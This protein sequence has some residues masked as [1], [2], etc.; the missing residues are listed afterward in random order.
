MAAAEALEAELKAAPKPVWSEVAA[1]LAETRREL[2]LRGK[3]KG[4]SSLSS[5]GNVRGIQ[6]DAGDD[7]ARGSIIDKRRK[8][9]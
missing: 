8:S 7:D 2:S 4:T 1:V 5:A 3:T 9:R 6:T